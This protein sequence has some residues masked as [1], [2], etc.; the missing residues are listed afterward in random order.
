[1]PS[2][3]S[4]FAMKVV[5]NGLPTRVNKKYRHLKQQDVCQICGQYAED[6]YH[7]LVACPHALTLRQAM[8]EHW[9]LPSKQV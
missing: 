9:V 6:V 1:M 3:V 8:R 2:K 4:I 7:A 5:N